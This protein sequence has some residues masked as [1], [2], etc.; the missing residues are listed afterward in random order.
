MHIMMLTFQGSVHGNEV[1]Y[2]S[3][4]LSFFPQITW[5]TATDDYRKQSNIM[6]I[7]FNELHL[8]K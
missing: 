6:W 1:I 7:N 2:A 5:E 8:S 4:P 3:R